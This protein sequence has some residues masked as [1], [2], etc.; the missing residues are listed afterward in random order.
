MRF[1]F[2]VEFPLRPVLGDNHVAAL[3]RR[4]RDVRQRQIGDLQHQALKLDLGRGVGSAESHRVLRERVAKLVE[5]IRGSLDYYSS[6][7]EV[8]PINSVVVT[9]GGSLTPRLIE[10]LEEALHMDIRIAAPLADLDVS[11]SGL[12]QEQLSQIEPVAATAVGLATGDR[13]R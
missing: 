7:E 13:S 12:T 6:Q 2:K 10:Q 11:K 9:G 1:R 4:H 3:V 8:E 5:E